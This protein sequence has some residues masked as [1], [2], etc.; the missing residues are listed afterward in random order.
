MGSNRFLLGNQSGKLIGNTCFLS[1]IPQQQQNYYPLPSKVNVTKF[2]SF[3]YVLCCVYSAVSDCLQ[4]QNTG[5]GS[6]SFLQGIFPTQGSNPGLLR[7]RQLPAV[8]ET[9]VRSLGREDPLEK[10]VA[11]HSSML[12]WKIPWKETG[13]LQLDTTEEA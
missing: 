3:G 8:Q 7:C 2:L 9:Q 10:E 12:A 11:T 6:L 1:K 4:L 13:R 5:V